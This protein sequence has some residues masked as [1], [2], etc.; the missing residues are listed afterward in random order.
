MVSPYQHKTEPCFYAGGCTIDNIHTIWLQSQT[1]VNADADDD[2]RI[3]FQ[4]P[5]FNNWR[6]APASAEPVH[7]PLWDA[8]LAWRRQGW[9]QDWKCWHASHCHGSTGGPFGAQFYFLF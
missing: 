2:D 3:S 4:F 6:Q 1:A 7:E 9:T 5:V 8:A